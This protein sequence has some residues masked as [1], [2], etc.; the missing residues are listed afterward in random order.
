MSFVEIKPLI[1]VV[2]GAG[3]VIVAVIGL[4]RWIRRAGGVARVAWLLLVL[5][6]LLAFLEFGPPPHLTTWRLTRLQGEARALSQ[7]V[8]AFHRSHGFWPAS[9]DQ[10]GIQPVPITPFGAF[11]LSSLGEKGHCRIWVGD[12]VRD[13]FTYEWASDELERGWHL[14]R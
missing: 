1:Q 10:A 12:Y 7:A 6:G 5:L 14:D 2:A 11:R 8:M 4:L 9:L 3:V 13:G